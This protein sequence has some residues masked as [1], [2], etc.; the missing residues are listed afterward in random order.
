MKKRLSALLLP[1]LLLSGNAQAE[2]YTIE[3][4]VFSQPGYSAGSQ[5]SRTSA[6]SSNARYLS[7]YNGAPLSNL[8]Q[9]PRSSYRLGGDAAQLQRQGYPVLYHVAWLQDISRGNNL[10]VRIDSPDGRV[11]G[12]VRVDRG[13]YLHFRPD[14]LLSGNTS[15]NQ[16]RLNTPRRMSVGETHYLDHPLFGVLVRASR[17]N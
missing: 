1:C 10:P 6:D 2:L 12:S 13:Q 7:A 5:P 8:E 3:M 16:Y 4:V 9:L 14:L 17:A 11:E 15:S